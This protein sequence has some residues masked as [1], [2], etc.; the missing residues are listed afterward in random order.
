MTGGGAD[1][2]NS[3]KEEECYTD[4]ADSDSRAFLFYLYI[5]ITINNHSQKNIFK[6]LLLSFCILHF[7]VDQDV[8]ERSQDEDCGVSSSEIKQKVK[9]SQKKQKKRMYN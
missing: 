4:D 6:N 7:C 5:I 9:S 3:D 2:G 8:D 1:S